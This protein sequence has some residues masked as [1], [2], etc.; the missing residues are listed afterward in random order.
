[1]HVGLL[2]DVWQV[3]PEDMEWLLDEIEALGHDC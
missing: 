3:G 2:D 1:M